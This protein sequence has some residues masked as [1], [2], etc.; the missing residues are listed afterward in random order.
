MGTGIHFLK[1]SYETPM[2]EN[3]YTGAPFTLEAEFWGGEDPHHIR[4]EADYA[5]DH[6]EVER[7]ILERGERGIWDDDRPT[8]ESRPDYVASYDIFGYDDDDRRG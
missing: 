4:W 8:D 2:D 6:A 1:R 3:G 7:Y 5:E